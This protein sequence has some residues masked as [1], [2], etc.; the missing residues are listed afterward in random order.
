V[1]LVALLVSALA[2]AAGSQPPLVTTVCDVATDPSRFGPQPLKI[3]AGIRAGV[4]KELFLDGPACGRVIAL[5]IPNPPAESPQ[6]ARLLALVFAN[7][8][9]G[10]RRS[11]SIGALVGTLAPRRYA[12]WIWILRA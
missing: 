12:R 11:Q 8:S 10:V 6:V 7:Y 1:R 3:R 2:A 5:E 9:D 4:H